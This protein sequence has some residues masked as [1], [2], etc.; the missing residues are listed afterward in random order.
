MNSPLTYCPFCCRN[1]TFFRSWVCSSSCLLCPEEVSL[2]QFLLAFAAC[3]DSSATVGYPDSHTYLD[4]CSARGRRCQQILSGE[5]LLFKFPSTPPNDANPDDL[6]TYPMDPTSFSI[7]SIYYS[8]FM[9][10][11][12]MYMKYMQR[13]EDNSV[14]SVLLLALPEFWGSQLRSSGSMASTLPAEPLS[15]VPIQC[16]DRG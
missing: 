12:Y 13:L 1:K 15:P 4:Y 5:A 9:L 10:Y 7:L 14:E 16:Y 3:Q 6:L 8:E 2:Y 11:V